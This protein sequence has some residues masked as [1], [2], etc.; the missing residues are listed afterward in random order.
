MFLSQESINEEVAHWENRADW[1]H[2]RS[3]IY[4]KKEVWH[5]ERFQSY[6]WDTNLETLLPA[7]CKQC[8]ANSVEQ[9]LQQKNSDLCRRMRKYYQQIKQENSI[10]IEIF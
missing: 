1:F 3:E 5:G 8:G 4:P 2:V 10:I 9:P 6:F 7:T